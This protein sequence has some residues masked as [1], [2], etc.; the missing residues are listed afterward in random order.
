MR[1][2]MG[3]N[4]PVDDEIVCYCSRDDRYLCYPDDVAGEKACKYYVEKEGEGI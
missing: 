3:S 4:E 1:L 2:Y